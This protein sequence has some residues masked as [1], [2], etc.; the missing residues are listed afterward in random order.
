MKKSLLNGSESKSLRNH[1]ESDSRTSRKLFALLALVM[2][3]S[4]GQMWGD[5]YVAVN[6]LTDGRSYILVAGGYAIT[7]SSSTSNWIDGTD[8]SSSIS[9]TTLTTTAT[10]IVWVAKKY[11]NGNTTTWSFKNGTKYIQNNSGTTYRNMTYSTTESKYTISSNKIYSTG[12][13]ATDK[14]LNYVSSNGFRM[15]NSNE[16]SYSFTFYELVEC[17]KKIT[18]DTPSKTGT[19]TIVFDKTSPV[20]TCD[21]ETTVKATVTPGAGY[22]CSSLS[23]S[24]GDVDVSPDP[25]DT[26]PAYPSAQE[27]T[28]TFDQNTNATLTSSVTFSSYTDQFKDYMHGNSISNKSGNYGTMPASP[29]DATPGDNYCSKKHY[30][31]A[32]WVVESEIDLETGALKDGATVVP[33]GETGHYA[34]GVTWYAVWAKE[35]EVE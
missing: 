1:F 25:T 13:G 2:C 3:I 11:T 14:Y 28:L 34:T 23:F 10:N 19:G 29:G 24:G 17:D 5:D 20:A 31:F 4:V 27:Y 15:Y 6:S 7:A 32:G 26:K 16:G 9:G 8:V 21:G 12:S 33:A 22:Y 35:N 30:K 18:L